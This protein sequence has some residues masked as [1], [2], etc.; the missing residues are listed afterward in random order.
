MRP[1]QLARIWI[2]LAGLWLAAA[3]GAQSDRPTNAEPSFRRHVIPLLSR[4]G[5][6]ARECH[7]SFAGQGGFQLSLFGYDFEADHKEITQDADGGEGEVRVNLTDPAKSLLVM[8]PTVQMK[9]KGKERIKKDSWEH[10]LLVRWIASGAKDDS[11]KTGEF[12]RLEVFPREIVFKNPGE[13]AQLKVLA[14]WKDGTV[15]DVTQLT[16]FRSNDDSVAGLSDQGFVECKGKGDTHVVAFYD[17]GVTP[18]PVMLPVGEFVGAKYPPVRTPTKVDELIVAKL[19][20]LG[21]VPSELCSDAEFLRRAS[22][23]VAGTL[24]TPGEVTTFLANQSPDKRAKKIDE[25]LDSPGHA[26]WWATR[27]CDFTGNSA[28]EIFSE[29]VTDLNGEFARQWWD[30]IYRRV[31]KNEPYDKL[32]A[33]IILAT[34]RS[35]PGQSYK[36]YALEMASYL[37]SDHRADFAQ[38]ESMPYFWA[39]KNVQKPEDRALAF[40]HAFLGVRIECAQCHK[41]PFDQWTKTDYVQFQQFFEPVR[42]DSNIRRDDDVNFVTVTKEVRAAAGG[43]KDMQMRDAQS[44]EIRR[45][46][47]AG[48]IIPVHEVY[49][50]TRNPRSTTAK[51]NAQAYS[52]RVLTPKLLGGEKVLLGEYADP[53]E[54]LMRWLR[55]KE[56]PFFARAF[57]NR[58]WAAYFHRGLIE[59][60][61]DINLAN[62]PVNAELMDYL[63][64][65]FIA[66]GYD[67]KRLHRVILSSDAYQRSWRPNPSN[68]LDEKNFS[69]FIL[70]R[71][72]AEV[73][74]DAMTLATA[75]SERQRKFADDVASRQIGPNVAAFGL[76]EA[77]AGR[78][79]P[80]YALTAFGKPAREVNCDCERTTVPT[81]LQALYTRNDPETLARIESQR[82]EMPAWI[83]ELRAANRAEQ[84]GTGR[85]DPVIAE[86]FLRTVSRPPTSEELQKAGADIAAAKDPI[87]GVRDLLWAMLNT[88][89]FTVNH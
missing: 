28:R 46:I 1:R 71:L 5:C 3:A 48:E 13:K 30:W 80:D 51:Q 84:A 64:D 60:A 22:L 49:I 11:V 68:E 44:G 55:S 53:R 39:R 12:D 43:G 45:R 20:K 19:R 34:S 56:N 9:H 23:D 77:F 73:L 7:G 52:G 27:L 8:K 29:G 62:P 72:P 33:G 88:R 59:P 70:R 37:R 14:H 83:T 32:A 47:D 31:A 42:Y 87:N 86:V 74:L 57:V 78:N 6:S 67:M 35:A 66:H 50:A 61:D 63:A 17:N 41:H 24:P 65:D 16:R 85:M 40:A 38:R 26:A 82:Q 18:I 4:I 89:E 36:D 58:V 15:E 21:V 69:R 25:L 79:L 2:G 54:P 10:Q 75:A 81:L 76:A